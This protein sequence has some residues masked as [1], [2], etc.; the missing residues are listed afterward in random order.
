MKTLLLLLLS[1]A[2]TLMLIPRSDPV[3]PDFEVA[4]EG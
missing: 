3:Q 2:V 4:M 1:G